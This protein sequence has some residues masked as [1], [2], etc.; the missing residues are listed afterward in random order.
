MIVYTP[1]DLPKIEP[2]DW[3][4][5]WE[6]WNQYSGNLTKVIS[7]GDHSDAAVGRND[8]WQG[9]DIYKDPLSL[10]GWRAPFYDIK[11]KLPKLYNTITS[12][13][14]GNI[15]Q[16]RLV[17]SKVEVCPHSDDVKDKWVARAYFHY[18]SPKEQWYFTRP[19]DRHGT[20]TYIT[21]P[22]ETNWFAY[23]DK[24]CCHA[25]DYDVRYPK[26]LLQVFASS[27]P[28]ELVDTSIKKYKDYTIT[29]N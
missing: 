12:L 24:H 27:I 7:N 29:Y 25:T 14:I 21:R 8:I 9:L 18:T 16:V 28:N 17:S 20:R 3:D 19:D 10:N 22:S 13:P 1:L 15:R 23:N 2:D 11:E 4:V 26:I 5:F 6:I